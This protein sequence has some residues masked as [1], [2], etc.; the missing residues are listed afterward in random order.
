MIRLIRVIYRMAMILAFATV[1]NHVK[2][3]ESN[4]S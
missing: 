2:S 4:I 3:H 1:R